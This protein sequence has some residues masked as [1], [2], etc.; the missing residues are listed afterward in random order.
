MDQ[1]FKEEL[2]SI[3]REEIQ[4]AV[5]GLETRF[6]SLKE[7]VSEIKTRLDGIDEDINVMNEKMNHEFGRLL[8]SNSKIIEALALPKHLRAEKIASG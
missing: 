5:G 4:E 6:D 1:D 8:K 7:G 2:R 3:I